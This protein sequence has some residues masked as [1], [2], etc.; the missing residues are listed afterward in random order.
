[1]EDLLCTPGVPATLHHRALVRCLRPP[2]L[3]H[4]SIT[5]TLRTCRVKSED[6]SSHASVEPMSAPDAL[7]APNHLHDRRFMIREARLSERQKVRTPRLENGARSRSNKRKTYQPHVRCCHAN[8]HANMQTPTA[9]TAYLRYDDALRAHVHE[10][11][12]DHS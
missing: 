11:T 3:A 2:I 9:H 7:T 6:V 10:P 1:M 8:Y 4:P 12:A 5:T